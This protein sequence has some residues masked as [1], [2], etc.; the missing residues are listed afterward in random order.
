MDIKESLSKYIEER[1]KRIKEFNE[2]IKN[3]DKEWID[4]I[5]DKCTIKIGDVFSHPAYNDVKTSTKYYIVS[6]IKIGID[7]TISISGNKLTNKSLWSKKATYMFSTS[8]YNN[9]E[10][11]SGFTKV[12]GNEL[13]NVISRVTTAESANGIIPEAIINE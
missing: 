11:N 9:F 10:S 8:I 2:S 4:T 5:K 6:D 12:V 3:D 7:G 1:N 13:N